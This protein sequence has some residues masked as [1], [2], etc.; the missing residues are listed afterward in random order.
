MINKKLVNRYVPPFAEHLNLPWYECDGLRLY[1]DSLKCQEFVNDAD[2]HF[3]K[4]EVINFDIIHNKRR[5][6]PMQKDLKTYQSVQKKIFLVTINSKRK[7]FHLSYIANL[8]V[9]LLK[10]QLLTNILRDCN[11]LFRFI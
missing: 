7:I 2:E 1:I 11:V 5:S 10:R 6:D 9:S 3:K 8:K 4:A